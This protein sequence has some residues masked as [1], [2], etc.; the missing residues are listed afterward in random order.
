MKRFIRRQMRFFVLA[1]IDICAL[2][3]GIVVAICDGLSW[4]R[5]VALV[6]NH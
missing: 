1:A 3:L 4:R 2:L 5:R 6:F